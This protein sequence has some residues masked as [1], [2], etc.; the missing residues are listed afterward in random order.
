MWGVEEETARRGAPRRSWLK[1]PEESLG[2][3]V[4]SGRG[5]DLVTRV[6]M[7]LE[8]YKLEQSGLM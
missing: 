2:G 7:T 1:N 6:Q 5:S 3:P 4:P 8:R